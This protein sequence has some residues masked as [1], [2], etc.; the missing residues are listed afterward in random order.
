MEKTLFEVVQALFKDISD[1]LMRSQSVESFSHQ[2]RTYK[3]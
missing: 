2:R 1:I 3:I